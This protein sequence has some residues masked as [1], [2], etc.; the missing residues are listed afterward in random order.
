M[1][2]FERLY[3]TQLWDFLDDFASVVETDE[4]NT[5]MEIPFWI[6][7]KANGVYEVH[8]EMPNDLSKFITKARL[9]GDNPQ[10]IKAEL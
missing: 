9:G 6:Q 5:Y 1:T 3:W 10:P 2:V 8:P 4:G 7:K